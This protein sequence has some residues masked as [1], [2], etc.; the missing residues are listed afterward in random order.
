MNLI[1]VTICILGVPYLIGWFTGKGLK[2]DNV[3]DFGNRWYLGLVVLGF[4]G[5]LYLITNF[6]VNLII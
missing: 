5:I 4:V 2:M 6:I 3:T 1:I